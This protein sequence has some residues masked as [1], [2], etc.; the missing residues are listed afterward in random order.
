M[1][2]LQT[3]SFRWP[4]QDGHQ[5]ASKSAH[6]KQRAARSSPIF[7]ISGWPTLPTPY[8]V[9][10]SRDPAPARFLSRRVLRERIY[11]PGTRLSLLLTIRFCYLPYS[12]RHVT[13]LHH[14][15]LQQVQGGRVN[16]RGTRIHVRWFL[17]CVGKCF[18]WVGQCPCPTDILTLDVFIL[19]RLSKI[20]WYLCS[21]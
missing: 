4:F 20:F 8:L 12:G 1:I 15:L 10:L 13:N 7:Q 2:Y 21:S 14:G 6:P 18:E 3:T 5:L 19:L 9:D 17:L 11:A 16:S